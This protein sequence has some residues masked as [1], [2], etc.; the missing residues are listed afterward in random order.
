[1][2]VSLALGALVRFVGTLLASLFLCF[3]LAAFSGLHVVSGV[4]SLYFGGVY[5]PASPLLDDVTLQGAFGASVRVAPLER[6][7]SSEVANS[8]LS[9]NIRKFDDLSLVASSNSYNENMLGH[10]FVAGYSG[11]GVRLE[12][13]F[14][15]E[16][17][18]ISR[19][20]FS[21]QHGDRFRYSLARIAVN[22][23][24][25]DGD[26][27]VLRND[28]MSL[29]GSVASM[30][31]DVEWT[32]VK[33]YVCAG[34]GI[35]RLRTFRAEIYSFAYQIK[36]GASF[37]LG[38]GLEGFCGIY[39]HDLGGSGKVPAPRE[40]DVLIKGQRVTSKKSV[41]PVDPVLRTDVAYLG[42]EL[43]VRIYP[44]SLLSR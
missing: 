16:K 15:R 44:V 13:E 31:K 29:V 3:P 23:G 38:R 21:E 7:S 39:Y 5:K 1:M 33:P 22:K 42:F 28:G 14:L 2:K 10:A 9:A 8:N 32:V 35:E 20:F 30:C 19:G 36:G 4:G 18:D 34:F 43:G 26:V 11:N 27:L 40:R 12:F 41:V 25:E 6:F 37:K 24:A 17:F